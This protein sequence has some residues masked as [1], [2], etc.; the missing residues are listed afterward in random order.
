MLQKHYEIYRRGIQRD[1]LEGAVEYARKTPCPQIEGNTLFHSL[2]M[3]VGDLN[4]Y[5]NFS[6]TYNYKK[7]L[8]QHQRTILYLLEEYVA[9][10][11]D[12]YIEMYGLDN[13]LLADFITEK[14][15]GW[16]KFCKHPYEHKSK[17]LITPRTFTLSGEPWGCGVSS[18]RLSIDT[19]ELKI[20]LLAKRDPVHIK[21]MG[22]VILGF[23]DRD[24]VVCAIQQINMGWEIN[25]WTA[26]LFQEELHE[27]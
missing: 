10:F 17:L 16:F 9:S 7:T 3:H 8:R 13:S 4:K 27:D 21:D 5:I 11:L 19:E 6:D 24:P 25:D 18:G 2:N 12:E 14:G 1:L 23:Q 15:W 22:R 20:C 26:P